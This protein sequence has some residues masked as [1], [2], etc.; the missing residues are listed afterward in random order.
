V[1]RSIAKPSANEG[2]MIVQPTFEVLLMSLSK[3]SGLLF[4]VLAVSA[5]SCAKVHAATPP[6]PDFSGI[7]QLNDAQ[8]DSSSDIAKRYQTEKKQEQAHSSQS[9]DESSTSSSA[10]SNSFGGGRGGRHGSGG[11]SSGGGGSDSGIH[12]YEDSYKFKKKNQS[13]DPT[14]PLFADDALLNVQQRTADM[15]VDF[16]NTDRLDTKFDGVTRPSLNGSAQIQTELSS[17]GMHMTMQFS[18]GTRLEQIWAKSTDGHHLTV[19]E[20]WTPSDLKQPITFKRVYDRLD[21]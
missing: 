8:S 2:T 9:S 15:Q 3:F 11:G 10:G 20:T 14:P 12:D 16:N 13:T 7:W 4:V 21:Q 17:D 1:I 6:T 5:L 19:T 18:D